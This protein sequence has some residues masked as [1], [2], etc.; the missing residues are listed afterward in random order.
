[1]Q[2][3]I[4]KSSAHKIDVLTACLCLSTIGAAFGATN[5]AKRAASKELAPIQVMIVGAYHMGNPGRDIN[6]AKVD[7]VLTAEKQKQLVEVAKRLAKFK[8]N[9]VA[10]KMSANGPDMTTTE[11]DK[12]T[13]D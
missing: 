2:N 1:M 3:V 7:S 13:P 12:F 9:K 5:E 11:F 8:P 10:V 4:L 6:N